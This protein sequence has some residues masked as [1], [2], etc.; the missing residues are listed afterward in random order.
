MRYKAVLHEV[1][2]GLKSIDSIWVNTE[3][4]AQKIGENGLSF[5]GAKRFTIEEE[6]PKPDSSE[7]LPNLK[8]AVENLEDSAR[9]ETIPD[10]VRLHIQNTVI[11][12]DLIVNKYE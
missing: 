8:S 10:D 11:A 7:W 4:E 1:K 2:S 5:Y 12:L 9:A 6:P 3:E